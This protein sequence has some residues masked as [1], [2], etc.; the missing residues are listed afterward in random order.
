MA[1]PARLAINDEGFAFDPATG[2]SFQIS[3]TG[4]VIFK[5]MRAG[6]KEAEIAGKL[7]EEYEV[8]QEEAARDVADFLDR[9]K[10]YGLAQ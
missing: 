4:L 5:A 3:S 2:E 8:T 6:M 9:L 10:A 1:T 7:T